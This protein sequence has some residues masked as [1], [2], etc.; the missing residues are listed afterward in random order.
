MLRL[1][2]EKK[3][4]AVEAKA[5]SSRHTPSAG[6]H[7]NGEDSIQS[8]H[9]GGSDVEKKPL[10]LRSCLNYGL[11][12]IKPPKK[13]KKKKEEKTKDKKEENEEVTEEPEEEEEEEISTPFRSN[14]RKSG[15]PSSNRISAYTKADKNGKTIKKAGEYMIFNT[16]V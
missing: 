14:N 8:S 15:K 3:L 11:P 13:K 9:G 1:F 12:P 5:S 6:D 4:K 2:L 7:S 10:K 16:Y